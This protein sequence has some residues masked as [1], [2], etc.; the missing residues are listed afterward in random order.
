[1]FQPL[2]QVAIFSF[3]VLSPGVKS[4]DAALP[5]CEKHSNAEIEVYDS[6]RFVAMSGKHIEGT[7]TGI[8]D[9]QEF[10]DELAGE[11][12]TVPEGTPDELTRE[13]E[14]SREEL[15]DVNTTEDI[16]D[17]FDAIQ[18]T[19]PRDIRLRSPVT[20]ERGNSKSRDPTW[21]E[22]ESGT[23]LAEVDSGWI[24]RKGMHGLGALQVVALE[25]RMISRP[26][27]YPSEE[28]FWEAV[29]ALREEGRTFPNTLDPRTAMSPSQHFHSH[30]STP[31]IPTLAG[32]P[33]RSEG[34][35][36]Q[37]RTN[38][39]A[40]SVGRSGTRC[41]TRG[42]SCLTHQLEAANRSPLPPLCG[43]SWTSLRTRLL[44]SSPRL[45]RPAIRRLQFHQA[46]VDHGIVLDIHRVHREPDQTDEPATTEVDDSER[47]D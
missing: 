35:H 5:D 25:E 7:P 18:H 45:A 36:G 6:G 4:I 26:D 39:E 11:Y 44:S 2:I 19:G 40:R 16:Q 14:K 34:S 29:D 13:P 8:T 9:A 20:H 27:E 30:N 43:P 41:A 21:R 31:S 28:T 22:S 42:M 33:P 15:A 38:F 32:G 12:A 23:G 10:T 47:D 37:R 24:E 3:E 17:V 46:C 1:M